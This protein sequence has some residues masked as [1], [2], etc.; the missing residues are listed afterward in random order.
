MEKRIKEIR[1]E[2]HLTQ[3]KFGERI[4]TKS[5]TIAGYESGLRIPTNAVILAICREFSINE[6]WLRDG[7]GPMRVETVNDYISDLAHEHHLGASGTQL[8]R[9]MVE[10]VDELDEETASA[11]LDR[12]SSVI[13]ER[14]ERAALDAKADAHIGPEPDA[15]EQEA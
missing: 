7:I 12:L 14:A 9:L 3:A 4:G 15:D 10:A 13:A 2:A 8:L 6:L 5:N 11:I 1:N